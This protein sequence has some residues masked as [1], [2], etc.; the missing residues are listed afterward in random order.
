MLLS[1]TNTIYFPKSTKILNLGLEKAWEVPFILITN[2]YIA[3]YAL[4]RIIHPTNPK[5]FWKP[6]LVF[7]MVS[8]ANG[9]AVK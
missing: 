6:S 8:L 3:G 7:K 2:Y 9:H 1:R 5:F 4:S